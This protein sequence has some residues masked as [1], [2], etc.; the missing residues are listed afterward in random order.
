MS[1]DGD[2]EALVLGGS[3]YNGR[4]IVLEE[5]SRL[6]EDLGITLETNNA[7]AIQPT[8]EPDVDV[9]N[10]TDT[11][12]VNMQGV[13]DPYMVSGKEEKSYDTSILAQRNQIRE[14]HDIQTNIS[15]PDIM[16]RLQLLEQLADSKR[17]AT[18][19]ADTNTEDID[20]NN[21]YPEDCYSLIALSGPVSNQWQKKKIRS[22]AFG[23]VVFLFQMLFL[24]L[25][26]F[27]V[28]HVK[29][30]TVEDPGN[31]DSDDHFW[32]S[33]MPPNN[34]HIV[35]VT[36]VVSLLAF[37]LFP[38]SSLQDVVKA[39]QWFPMSSTKENSNQVFY[40]RFACILRGM[41][42]F[43]ACLTAWLLVMTSPSVVDIILNFTAINFVSNLDDEAFL[44]AK[45]GVFGKELRKDTRR[46]EDE[47]LPSCVHEKGRQ[48]WCWYW[49][50]MACTSLLFFGFMTY[51]LVLQKSDDKWITTIFR[52]NF[53]D[54]EFRSYSGCYGLNEDSRYLTRFT[55]NSLSQGSTT[56]IGYCL[57]KRQWYIFET[58][59][60]KFDPCDPGANAA[61]RSSQI[62]SFDI[63]EAFEERW[64]ST[65]GKPLD[66]FFFD[67]DMEEKDLH[68]NL[69]LGDGVCDNQ[70]NWEAFNYD[71]GDCCAT[72]CTGSKCGNGAL[73]SVFGDPSAFGTG[74][75]DCKDENM[76][77]ITVQLNDIVS[78]RKFV[79]TND[80]LFF[81]D[82]EAEWRNVTPE[83]TYF[84]VEC[85]EKPVMSV[86][87]EPSMI[88]ESQTVMV[89]DGSSCSVTAKGT[90][91]SDNTT[92]GYYDYVNIFGSEMAVSEPIWFINYTIS[93]GANRVLQNR[94]IDILS[95]QTRQNSDANFTVFPKCFLEEL[96]NFIDIA[97][98]YKA[99][100][101]PSEEA[102]HW[103]TEDNKQI[104][105]CGESNFL[106]RYALSTIN[107]AMGD[108]KHFISRKKYCLWQPIT[109]RQGQVEAF[110]L[111]S[112]RLKGDIPSA[113]GILSGLE[114]LKI[115][116][117]FQI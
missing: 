109:C 48:V 45:E 117:S 74:F 22:F 69:T 26:F 47:K 55:Y 92:N 82:N 96:Q 58:R 21:K 103:L 108:T 13:L 113:I 68:C 43:V 86:F 91:A 67:S 17:N 34:K 4:E 14:C 36:Q 62:D 90:Q 94:E 73:P 102:F 104:S 105:Q 65:S 116:K 50:V 40:L 101:G 79:D 5:I 10:D 77:P 61:V 42:G 56:S 84:T 23:F 12:T 111:P 78:S 39:V 60:D 52:V 100:S 51:V 59:D 6:E 64:V 35:V 2:E 15:Y 93:H 107:F 27:G 30:G 33:F 53:N 80:W 72:T 110:I 44:L 63:S 20:N 11:S 38:D 9:G 115:C 19:E 18:P 98:I 16:S 89:E 99:A 70:F 112:S 106:E 32:A 97:D 71:D 75:T 49:I 25:L 7:T 29:L 54:I 46:I 8:S 31:P 57:E 41:Q 83:A 28:V 114:T 24:G 87:V 3:F 85:E 81:N 76:V 1:G 95:Q 88:N 66:L 37:V